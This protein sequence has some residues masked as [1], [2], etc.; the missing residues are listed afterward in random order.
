MKLLRLA[1]EGSS[2]GGGVFEVEGIGE[3]GQGSLE[4]C[5]S[6]EYASTMRR[7]GEIWMGSRKSRG[8]V[9]MTFEGQLHE[10]E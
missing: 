6:L 8:R 4:S 5:A 7:E 1:S 10:G 2:Y 9:G 3:S